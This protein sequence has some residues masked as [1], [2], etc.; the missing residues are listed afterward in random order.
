[1][2]QQQALELSIKSLIRAASSEGFRNVDGAREFF[3]CDDIDALLEANGE[4]SFRAERTASEM[5]MP[6]KEVADLCVSVIRRIA[7][8]EG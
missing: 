6:V 4:Q 8:I 7:R 5:T 2:T 1:M 3:R